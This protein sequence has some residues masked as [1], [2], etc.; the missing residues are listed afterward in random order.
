MAI[1][2]TIT[3]GAKI[4]SYVFFWPKPATSAAYTCH[5]G[6]R[7]TCAT[8]PCLRPITNVESL[9][10]RGEVRPDHRAVLHVEAVGELFVGQAFGDSTSSPAH[11]TGGALARDAV[12]PCIPSTAAQHDE[13]GRLQ[14]RSFP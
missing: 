4:Q 12:P 2:H 7:P 8:Q 3:P 5:A 13:A 14:P 1:S 6:S 11:S 10:D 9:E